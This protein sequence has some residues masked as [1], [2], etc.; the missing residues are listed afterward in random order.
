M[1]LLFFG[2]LS[3]RFGRRIVIIWA[4]SLFA[5]S[6]LLFALATNVVFLFAGRVLQGA[7]AGLAMG[8]ATA[9]LVENNISGNPRFASSLATVVT[10][11]GLTFALVISGALARFIPLPLFWSY[12]VLLALTLVTIMVLAMTPDDRP[13]KPSRRQFASLRVA[14]GLGRIFT[15]ATLAVSLGYGVGAI[16]L[17]LGAHMISQFAQTQDTL[18]IGILLG[19]SSAAIGL[20]ALLR[21]NIPAHIC[22][23]TGTVLTIIS[24]A[25]MEVAAAAAG[26]LA[27]FCCGVWSVVRPIPC[28]SPA[29]W[30]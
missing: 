29:D 22:G 2:N 30:G 15:R 26:S 5:T 24:L 16:F 28:A 12:I 3:D 10:V 8:A 27:V 13:E 14:P 7:G 17:S 20:T 19:S 9:S 1:V 25:I 4:L 18:M 11:S 23:W 21:G 6:A